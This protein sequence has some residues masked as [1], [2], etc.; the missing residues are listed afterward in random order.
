MAAE[1]IISEWATITIPALEKFMN[2]NF[3]KA[4]KTYEAGN[5]N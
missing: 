4:F 2:D 1:E 3:E 5:T